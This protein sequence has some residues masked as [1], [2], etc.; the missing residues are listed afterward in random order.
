MD[1][2]PGDFD[3]VQLKALK[4]FL[5]TDEERS[6]LQAYVK[7]GEGSAEKMASIMTDLS[8]CEKYMVAMMKV[9]NAAAKFD[10]MIFRQQF[11]SRLDELMTGVNTVKTACDEVRSSERL[12]KM[13]AVILTLVNQINTGGDGNLAIGFS[14]DALLK[15][16]EV[17]MHEREFHVKKPTLSPLT[18]CLSFVIATGKSFR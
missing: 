5:P 16:N 8:E 7:K 3:S 9:E 17:R 10:C 13:M 4:E 18:N 2:D 6:A 12:R 14:L 1:R 15:L 11:K